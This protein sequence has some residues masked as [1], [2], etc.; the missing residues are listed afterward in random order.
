MFLPLVERLASIYEIPAPNLAFLE[1]VQRRFGRGSYNQVTNEIRMHPGLPPAV[2]I[3]T[4]FHECH[5]A[6]QTS[7]AAAAVLSDVEHGVSPSAALNR[8]YPAL[9]D[10]VGARQKH[11]DSTA[12]AIGRVVLASNETVSAAQRCG[13]VTMDVDEYLATQVIYRNSFEELCSSVIELE[14]AVWQ[15]EEALAAAEAITGNWRR[16]LHELGWIGDGVSAV[17]LRIADRRCGALRNHIY[18]LSSEILAKCERIHDWMVKWDVPMSDGS[19]EGN[20]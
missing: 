15:T 19:H 13:A 12:V 4:L 1:P 10:A 9:V 2:F 20:G 14:V 8:F 6:F 3:R 17:L 11:L 7:F 18:E 16:Q 5:H